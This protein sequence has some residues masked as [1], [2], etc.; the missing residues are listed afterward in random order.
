MSKPLKYKAG[1]H[2]VRCQ[3]CATV[4][5]SSKMRKEWNGLIVC[6]RCYEPRHPQDFVKGRKENTRA[7]GLVNPDDGET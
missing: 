6:P 4:H 2:W 1:D 3:R 5:R 7:K